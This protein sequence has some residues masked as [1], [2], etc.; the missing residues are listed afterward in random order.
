MSIRIENKGTV[1]REKRCRL[2][3]SKGAEGE[4]CAGRF[5]PKC[6]GWRRWYPCRHRYPIRNTQKDG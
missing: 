1:S 6:G 4:E 2:W 5:F 3:Q